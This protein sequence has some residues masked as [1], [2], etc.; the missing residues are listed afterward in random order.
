MY[1]RKVPLVKRRVIAPGITARDQFLIHSVAP[2]APNPACIVCSNVSPKLVIR[3]NVDLHTIGTLATLVL[4]QHLAM[5]APFI[6]CGSSVLWEHEETEHLADAPLRR[7]VSADKVLVVGDLNQVV[8]WT[9]EIV[10]DPTL[11][12]VAHF[13]ANGLQNAGL[14]EAMAN[15]KAA[16]A[17]N[18]DADDDD[19]VQAYHPSKTEHKS[20]PN[21]REKVDVSKIH[22][23]HCISR[24]SMMLRFSVQ[25]SH[26][27]N[28]W[29]VWTALFELWWQEMKTS[30]LNRYIEW[31]YPG[32]NEDEMLTMG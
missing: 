5:G 1:V 19:G 17:V 3:L 12:D 4:K 24:P 26:K 10:H 11:G 8:E 29:Y 2:E 6:N 25:T 22:E 13:S 31:R 7:W 23:V 21:I 15:R 20:K 28:S 32:L 9:T 27:G 14:E 30:L 16:A 18:N